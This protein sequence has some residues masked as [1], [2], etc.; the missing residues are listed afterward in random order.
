MIERRRLLLMRHGAVE[1]FTA[2]GRPLPPDQVSLTSAGVGQAQAI[3]QLLVGAGVRIDRAWSSGL[4]RTRQTAAQVLAAMALDVRID[5]W[6]Q[7]EEIRPGRLADIPPDGL[8][9]AFIAPF[10]GAVP[11]E[12]RF[13]GG[14]TIGDLVARVLPAL[15]H[16]LHSDGWDTALLVAH[17]GV[18]R[19][20]L[21]WFLT[22]EPLF[23]GGLAQDPGCLNIIDIGPV[24]AQT[25]VRVVNFCP[26][27]PLQ[28]ST[29]ASTMEELLQ[30]YLRRGARALLPEEK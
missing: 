18:N 10:Q 27:E 15:Q 20:L 1:Y 16:L 8:T 7:F 3:G 4:P 21:S 2:D 13:L 28:T 30:Q 6:P 25:V 17:G 22:G 29:R 9:E 19:A 26:L 24:P 14:E 5:H 12:T 23:F 11:P